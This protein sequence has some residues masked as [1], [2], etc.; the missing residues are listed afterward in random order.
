MVGGVTVG[1]LFG[2]TRRDHLVQRS[3]D[4]AALGRWLGRWRDHVADRDLLEADPG[5]GVSPVR[6]WYSTH[7]SA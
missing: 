5:N 4:S 6:H 1:G 2:Q 3:R 7:A